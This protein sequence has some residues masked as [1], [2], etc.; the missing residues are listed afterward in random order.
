MTTFK[1][2]YHEAFSTTVL[3]E[4]ETLEEAREMVEENGDYHREVIDQSVDDISISKVIEVI[5]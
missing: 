3:V 4:A 5:K 2:K 1:I